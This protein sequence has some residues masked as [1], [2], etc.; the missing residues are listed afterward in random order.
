MWP[1]QLS[2]PKALFFT[3]RYFIFVNNIFGA[4]CERPYCRNEERLSDSFADS[5][6]TDRTQEQCYDA[7]L[8]NCIAS[9]LLVV[10]AEGALQPSRITGSLTSTVSCVI[11]SSV[12]L[13]WAREEDVLLPHSAIHRQYVFLRILHYPLIHSKAV[14]GTTYPLMVLFLKSVKCEQPPTSV[15]DQFY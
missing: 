7:F 10:G 3:L 11:H 4:L 2:I 6:P 14:H 13:R 9:T 12:R 8:R 5:L 1:T 15:R